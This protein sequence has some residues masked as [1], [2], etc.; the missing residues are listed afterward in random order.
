MTTKKTVGLKRLSDGRR[1]PPIGCQG[2]R[3]QAEHS[4]FLPEVLWYNSNRAGL[5][6]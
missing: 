5:Y 1:W 3:C 4:F 2:A 6:A